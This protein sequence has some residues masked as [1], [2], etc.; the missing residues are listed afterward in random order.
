MYFLKVLTTLVF[1]ACSIIAAPIPVTATFISPG[2]LV[3]KGNNV[4]PVTVSIIDKNQKNL[5][6]DLQVSINYDYHLDVGDRWD[7]L[8]TPYSDLSGS[9][10]T[11]LRKAANLS[12]LFDEKGTSYYGPIQFAIWSLYSDYV[13]NIGY[14]PMRADAPPGIW[15]MFT[16]TSSGLSDR[17]FPAALFIM[18][19]DNTT[20]AE[21]PEPR[22]ILMVGIALCLIFVSKW[23]TKHHR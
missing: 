9:Q 12:L 3:Y 23:R 16:P 15:Y 10:L 4:G 8:L 7:G 17:R 18:S 20:A 5:K 11:T 21:V 19:A 22:S 14:L 1:L 6:F 13:K 2:S